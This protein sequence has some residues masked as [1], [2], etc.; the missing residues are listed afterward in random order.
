MPLRRCERVCDVG[1]L[2]HELQVALAAERLD[3]RPSHANVIVDHEQPDR[4][5]DGHGRSRHDD[6][7]RH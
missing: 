3:D 7:G 4:F 6:R 2:A 5:L 1:S